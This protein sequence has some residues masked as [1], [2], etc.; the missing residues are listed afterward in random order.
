MSRYVMAVDVGTTGSTVLLL[1]PDARVVRRAERETRQYYPRPGWVEHDPDEMW[2]TAAALMKR[3]ARGIP[4]S[5]IAAIG[6]TNHRETAVLWNRKSG[7]PLHRAIVWQDRR[8][9]P[10]CDALRKRG[11]EPEIRRRTG[12]VLDA[13]FSATKVRWMLDRFR[14]RNA[15]FG[16]V[17]SW[18]LWNLTGGRAHATDYT[19]ASRTQL[20][21][22]HRREW[23]PALLKIFG[24]PRELLPEVK[25]SAGFFGTTSLLGGE[26]PVTGIAGDQ[27][28]ALFGQCCFERGGFKNTYGTGCFAVLNTGSKPV[29][30]RHGLLT[31]LACDASGGPCYA[32]EGSVFIAGA[33]VQYL[34][35]SLGIIR[36]AADTEKLAASVKDTGG[37]VFV[38]A[39]V[40]LGAPYWDMEARGAVLGLTRGSG[41]AEIARAALESI[42]YQARDVIDAMSRDARLRLRSLRVDGG[43]TENRFLMQFQADLLGV[44]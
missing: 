21:N 41:R 39:F 42:A 7:R 20:F 35:D 32:L 1:D 9:S 29:A 15:A 2:R 4:P 3:A 25:P 17:D 38:P 23:D 19:N 30:S 13:Y 40:G 22:I 12:L 14:P 36:H 11:L 16:T 10:H 34:R 27:Q 6:L 44:P 33:A 37:V 28:A 26:I 31:T 43:A 5:R 24:V 8:T 18:I